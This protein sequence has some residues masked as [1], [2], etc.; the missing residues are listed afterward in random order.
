[1]IKLLTILF[2]SFVTITSCEFQYSI[3]KNLEN[4]SILEENGLSCASISMKV[5]DKTEE[6]NHFYYG[7]RVEIIFDEIDRTKKEDSL[8][9]IES[10]LLILKNNKD[11]IMYNP[12]LINSEEGTSM[13]PLILTTY[14]K[15][16]LPH[17][18]KEKYEL[19]INIW[20]KKGSGEIKY[21]LPFSV[22]TNPLLKIQTKGI[23][24][25]DVILFNSTKKQSIVTGE[26]SGEDQYYLIINGTKGLHLQN[27]KNYPELQLEIKDAQ[28]KE[29]I[30]EE[31]ALS[32]IANKGANPL[33]VQKQ[34]AIPFSIP[35][36][37]YKN[38]ISL[39]AI[40]KDKYSD[41]KLYI[42]TELTLKKEQN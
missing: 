24:R 6:R 29:I 19:I 26:I 8:M 17:L 42:Q 13:Q 37:I 36:G 1:M 25:T 39:K 38:P 34:I 35:K 22:Q 14:F 33:D 27:E 16:I 31:N 3:N 41:K 18:D 11:T 7:E 23:K 32:D 5:N 28:N 12:A 21:K 40:L 9:F 15:V 30:F 20:D 2:F 10:S 4:N